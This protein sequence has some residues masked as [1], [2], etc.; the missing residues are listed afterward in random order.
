M[1]MGDPM[2]D[3]PDGKRWKRPHWIYLAFAALV[4]VEQFVVWP[5]YPSD[6]L[7]LN[8]D[9]TFFLSAVWIEVVLSPLMGA[10]FVA[11][12]A[13]SL[14]IAGQI[15]RR[16]MDWSESPLKRK[17]PLCF[18]HFVSFGSWG[19]VPAT[20]MMTPYIGW[21]AIALTSAGLLGGIG[22]QYGARMAARRIAD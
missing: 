2:T 8:K 21:T 13:R 18:I 7:L 5:P 1:S 15:T 9:R 4:A 12:V 14:H 16:S 10:G 3:K 22:L 6:F 20:L 11:A 19:A 17:N